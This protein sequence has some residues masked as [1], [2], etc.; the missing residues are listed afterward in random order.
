MEH[1]IRLN[2]GRRTVKERGRTFEENPKLTRRR[3][4]LRSARMKVFVPRFP[5]SRKKVQYVHTI[6]CLHE[7]HFRGNVKEMENGQSYK[8]NSTFP[9]H[10]RCLMFH[11]FMFPLFAVLLVLVNIYDV[12][13]LV[14]ND[15]S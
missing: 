15:L 9:N 13:I 6:S 11:A 4:N 10:S 3:C 12:L 7:T 8:I 14:N 1:T 5:G 2:Q